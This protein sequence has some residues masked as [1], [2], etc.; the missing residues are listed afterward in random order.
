ML[1]FSIRDLFWLTLVV[2]ISVS[3]WV[4][5]RDLQTRNAQLAEDAANSK[6]EL[7]EFTERAQ[8]LVESMHASHWDLIEQLKREY[9]A[10]QVDHAR[11][12]TPVN[13]KTE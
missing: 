3:W 4:N 12:G 6:S 1:Q 5:F 10:Q 11:T 9:H 8:K 7:V 2:A 13:S